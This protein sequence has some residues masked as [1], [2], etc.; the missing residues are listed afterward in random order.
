[1]QVLGLHLP[2]NVIITIR[3]NIN[4]NNPGPMHIQ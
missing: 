4:D 3:S 2:K 1:M